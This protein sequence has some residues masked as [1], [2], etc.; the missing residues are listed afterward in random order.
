M[1]TSDPQ[2]SAF[3]ARQKQWQAELLALREV[4][5]STPVSE[6]LKWYKPCYCFEGRN[7]AALAGLKDHCWILFFKGALLTDAAGILQKA[8][9]NSQSARVIKF[10]SVQQVKALR[11]VLQ[12]YVKEAIAAEQAGRKVAFAKIEDR[13]LPDE[14]LQAFAQNPTLAQAFAALTP[15]RQ[16]G[17]L[18]H[19]GQA[20]QSST[21]IARIAKCTPAIL[22]GR[23]WQERTTKPAG[24]DAP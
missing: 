3:F 17:Y 7:I 6:T 13:V 4:F 16:R 19:F 5:L 11:P 24:T 10:T 15:G 20:K 14:L 9:E 2:A 23:G 22:L 8:G 18:L 12:R 1:G 21:R